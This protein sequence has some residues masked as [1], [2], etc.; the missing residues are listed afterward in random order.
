MKV[1]AD[2]RQEHT[3][4]E[5]ESLQQQSGEGVLER[6]LCQAPDCSMGMPGLPSFMAGQYFRAYVFLCGAYVWGL[7]NVSR[8]A[9]NTM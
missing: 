2:H 4:F 9:S 7:H 1:W 6:T 5:G 8:T 3:D